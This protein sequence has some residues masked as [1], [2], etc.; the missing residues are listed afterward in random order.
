[1]RFSFV[2][3][4]FLGTGTE[5]QGDGDGDGDSL[6]L[7][8]GRIRVKGSYTTQ[9]VLDLVLSPAGHKSEFEIYAQ[10]LSRTGSV[11]RWQI[12]S[13]LFMAPPKNFRWQF[14]ANETRE[15]QSKMRKL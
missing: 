10:H 3:L 2:F 9:P 7:A 13:A 5:C 4:C 15:E 8:R 12:D 14:A 11:H 1:M 6:R